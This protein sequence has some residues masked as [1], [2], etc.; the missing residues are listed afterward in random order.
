MTNLYLISGFLGAGK[1]TLIKKLLEEEFTDSKTALIENDFGEIS[2]DAA[3][4]RTGKVNVREI[5]SGCICCSLAGDF[6]IALEDLLRKLKPDNILIE[7]SGVGKLSDIE[8]GCQDPRIAPFAIIRKKITAVDVKRCQMYLENFGEFFEDQ[9]RCADTI[10]LTRTEQFPERTDAAKQ[11]VKSLNPYAKILSAPLNTLPAKE[12]LCG[13]KSEN[14]AQQQCCCA[15]DDAEG[16]CKCSTSAH[17]VFQ[18]VTIQTKHPFTQEELKQCF[19]EMKQL[20]GEIFRAKGIVPG[21]HG[22]LQVQYV[23]GNAMVTPCKTSG[24][25]VCIIGRNLC[26]PELLRIFYKE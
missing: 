11:L 15:H 9:I 10:L 2:I 20:S 6:V 17:E 13:E 12:L 26:Q 16:S 21:R 18:T 14:R 1:T 23:P 25:S 3:L 8:K 5:N 19:V 7:P 22:F 24:N 4:L